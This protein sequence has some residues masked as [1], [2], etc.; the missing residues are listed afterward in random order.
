MTA[1]SIPSGEN[2][3]HEGIARLSD[4][5]PG[6]YRVVSCYLKLEPRDKTRGKSPTKMKNRVRAALAALAREGLPRAVRD[7]VAADL[8]RVRGYVAEPDRLPAARG[9]AGFACQALGLFEVLPLPRVHRSRLRVEATPLVRELV[10]LEQEFGTILV[11]AVD[12][13]GARLFA[14]TAC[15]V[16][17]LPSLPAVASA[18]PESPGRA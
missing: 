17:E 8:E 5:E 10:A 14:V 7:G 18:V 16:V 9:I 11:A 6:P 13:T 15:D 3:V 1:L 4:I 2:P 12:R